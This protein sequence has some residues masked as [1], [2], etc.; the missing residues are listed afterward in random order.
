MEWSVTHLLK[1]LQDEEWPRYDLNI[2]EDDPETEVAEILGRR[3]LTM[4][5]MDIQAAREYEPESDSETDSD[6]DYS[7]GI[8]ERTIDDRVQYL[9][10]CEGEPHI[11]ARYISRRRLLVLHRTR[12][13]MFEN[14]RQCYPPEDVADHDA[15]ADEEAQAGVILVHSKV[16]AKQ[17]LHLPSVDPKELSGDYRKLSDLLL[18]RR[19]KLADYG[20]PASL[21][22]PEQI[23]IKGDDRSQVLVKF[24]GL[25]HS[26]ALSLPVG[27]V[28]PEFPTLLQRERLL[29]D[30][31]SKG[32]PPHRIVIPPEERDY[33]IETALPHFHN[34]TRSPPHL[35]GT[36]LPF[37]LDGVNWLRAAHHV[38]QNVILADDMG[39]GKTIQTIGYL[40]ALADRGVFGPFLIVVGL[41]VLGNW[42]EE[43]AKWVPS[44]HVVPYYGA[45]EDRQAIERLELEPARRGTRSVDIVLTTYNQIMLCTRRSPVARLRYR[46]MIVDEAHRLKGETCALRDR[47]AQ[48]TTDHIVLLSGTP[49]Q[50]TLTELWTLLHF[51]DPARFPTLEGFAGTADPDTMLE[52][53]VARLPEIHDQLRRVMLRRRKT[54][55]LPH[56]PPKREL[57]L[58]VDMLPEQREHY[59]AIF[60]SS[61]D[62]AARKFR[63]S[64][65]NIMMQLRKCCN[66]ALLTDTRYRETLHDMLDGKADDALGRILGMSGKMTALITAIR[67]LRGRGDRFLVYSQFTSTLD[68][69]TIVLELEGLEFVRLD[70]QVSRTDRETAVHRFNSEDIPVFLLSTRAG[71]EGLNLVSANTVIIF[72]SD[73]NPHRDIQALCRAHR[74]GQ[75]R[76]VHVF[77]LVTRRTV[78]ERILRK[79]KNKLVADH[80]VVKRM[81][82]QQLSEAE[83][84][85]LIKFGAKELFEEAEAEDGVKAI[86]YTAEDIVAM[87]EKSDAAAEQSAAER[88]KL[89]DAFHAKQREAQMKRIGAVVGTWDAAEGE[90]LSRFDKDVTDAEP[91]AEEE[92]LFAAFDVAKYQEQAATEGDDGDFWQ[93]V[94]A[95]FTEKDEVEHSKRRSARRIKSY[96]KAFVDVSDSEPEEE[97][98]E[99]DYEPEPDSEPEEDGPKPYEVALD[100]A[101]SGTRRKPKK[102]AQPHI[103]KPFTLPQPHPP[104]VG[105]MPLGG[106]PLGMGV[107]VGGVRWGQPTGHPIRDAPP[108]PPA[109]LLGFTPVEQAAVFTFLRPRGPIDTVTEWAIIRDRRSIAAPAMQSPLNH[110]EASLVA[111]SSHMAGRVKELAAMPT[112]RHAIIGARFHDGAPVDPWYRVIN[113]PKVLAATWHLATLARPIAR[114]IVTAER[115]R[116]A[117]TVPLPQAVTIEQQDA[118]LR[119]W[120]DK[121]AKDTELKYDSTWLTQLVRSDYASSFPLM[122][123]EHDVVAL[124][125]DQTSATPSWPVGLDNRIVVGMARHGWENSGLVYDSS[126][127][128]IETLREE[129]SYRYCASSQLKVVVQQRMKTLRTLLMTILDPPTWK[130]HTARYRAARKAMEEQVKEKEVVVECIDDD[131]VGKAGG[132]AKDFKAKDEDEVEVIEL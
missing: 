50:N 5:D 86:R 106:P 11:N 59:K 17:S 55:V 77:K 79:A 88:D 34:L 10:R 4:D 113:K 31:P 60:S 33:Y 124:V 35:T 84:G 69:L 76:A 58:P 25:P 19:K 125:I 9:C 74:V 123:I 96:K 3:V 27:Y 121:A 99:A 12:V 102:P 85:S 47:L 83:I 15:W 94:L 71:G 16:T 118:A 129:R 104:T 93:G 66:N 81:D 18:A 32:P 127:G 128:I 95:K 23:F 38:R 97:E 1:E 98:P 46:S 22:I 91:A 108:A 64:Y 7:E 49:M 116:A 44:M 78:E 80:L 100:E 89:S 109:Q 126:L 28:L 29:M 101:A 120:A 56:L 72:D 82:K 13:T 39:S 117:A 90:T 115:P 110:P 42:K 62:P 21:M 40:A 57:L 131:E 73:W 132:E 87:V 48:L 14:N 43:L 30:P 61:Y 41:S 51:V 52:A 105:G 103:I 92:D 122:G 75:Q 37:Q 26:D 20:L 2:Q 8:P 130:V 63:M 24:L 70:G 65:S 36:L 54:D 107:E 53:A 114:K 68:L 67:A 112:G 111:L 45:K 6:M 119:T